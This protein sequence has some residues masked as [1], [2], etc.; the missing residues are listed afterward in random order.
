MARLL[1]LLQVCMLTATATAMI[2]G[3]KNVKPH[4]IISGH[5]AVPLSSAHASKQHD[6]NHEHTTADTR[7]HGHG[8]HKH[9]HDVHVGRTEALRYRKMAQARNRNQWEEAMDARADANPEPVAAAE[10]GTGTGANANA[11]VY[12]ANA[13]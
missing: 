4:T 6:I 3:L 10:A 9:R 2:Q 11:N 8:I 7:M 12:V 1:L 5:I 13:R